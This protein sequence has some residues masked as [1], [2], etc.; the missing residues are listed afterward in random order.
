MVYS[1]LTDFISC[2]HCVLRYLFGCLNHGTVAQEAQY[3]NIQL[4]SNTT[5]FSV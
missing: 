4:I 2:I 3:G 1:Y 5:I